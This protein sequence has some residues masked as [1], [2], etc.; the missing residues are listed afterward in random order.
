MM[1]DLMRHK[2]SSALTAVSVAAVLLAG[3]STAEPPVCE[4]IDAV[5]HSVDTVTQAQLGEN[6]LSVVAGGL[7][8]LKA[9]LGQFTADAKA[10]FQPQT[11]ALRMSVDQLSS[12]VATAKADPTA[13]TLGGVGVAV[14]AVQ[15]AAVDLNAAVSKTC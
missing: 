2:S 12:S 6:G 14:S 10:Q 9:D 1:L 13:T 11:E 15:T 8:Q 3:C 4:S 5:R 7:T